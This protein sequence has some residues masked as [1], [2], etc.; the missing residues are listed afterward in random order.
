MAFPTERVAKATDEK[1]W[2]LGRGSPPWTTA[3]DIYK[4]EIRIEA[5]RAASRIVAG[6]YAGKSWPMDGV[7]KEKNAAFAALELAE[8]FAR[9]LE[10]GK[11]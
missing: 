5:L 9:W 3:E 11:R 2:P 6:T 8:Q 4:Q 10:D 1:D 7:G